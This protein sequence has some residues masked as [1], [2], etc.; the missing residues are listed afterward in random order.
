MH[1]KLISRT[2]R[3]SHSEEQ[4]VDMEISFVYQHMHIHKYYNPGM[5]FILYHMQHS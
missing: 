2:V 1:E 3:I 5:V 4:D